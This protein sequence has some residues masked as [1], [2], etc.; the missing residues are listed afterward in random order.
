MTSSGAAGFY[1]VEFY[2]DCKDILTP[3][4]VFS[5]WLPLHG[6]SVD[7]FKMI[8][9]SFRAAFPHSSVW[10]KY[11]A[12]FCMLLGTLDP[13]EIDF[14]R[15][16]QGMKQPRVLEH[17]GRCDVAEVWDLLD[18]FCFDGEGIDAAVG[19]GP[20]HTDEHPYL[21]YHVHRATP[22][23]D[24]AGRLAA[25][26]I[27]ADGRQRVRPFVVNIPEEDRV[28]AEAQLERWYRAT[29]ELTQAFWLESRSPFGVT[30]AAYEKAVAANP[31]DMNARFLFDRYLASYLCYAASEYHRKGDLQMAIKCLRQ[32][33]RLSPDTM[34]GA[35]ARDLLES[36]HRGGPGQRR[37]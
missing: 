36:F 17:L 27:L 29:K 10:Y 25:L 12:D 37:K 24:A 5:Q 23:M 20:L 15:F 33:A 9:R 7:D 26:A 21:E 19:P 31:A 35:K 32:A 28:W 34:S 4:G 2:K 1:T 30:K 16:E 8:L 14:P 13:L 18:F 3:D 11:T 6:V 22:S